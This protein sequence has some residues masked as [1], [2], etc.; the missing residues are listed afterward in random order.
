MLRAAD[1][2]VVATVLEAAFGAAAAAAEVL[3]DA[4]ERLL[5]TDPETLRPTQGQDADRHDEPES[6]NPDHQPGTERRRTPPA[7]S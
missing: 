2:A 7:A 6:E 3:R 5:A 4:G 1:P